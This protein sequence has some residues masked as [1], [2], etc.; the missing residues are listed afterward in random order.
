MTTKPT[1]DITVFIA[2]RDVT[3]DECGVGLSL[4]ACGI[5]LGAWRAGR[6][7]SL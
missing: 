1:S 4:A 7:R 2:C 6:R 5:L 3:C